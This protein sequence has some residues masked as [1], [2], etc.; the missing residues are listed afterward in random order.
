MDEGQVVH[1]ERTAGEC[2]ENEENHGAVGIRAVVSFKQEVVLLGLGCHTKVP[3][4]G[5]L[6][7]QKSICSQYW[8]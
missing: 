4:T 5:W 3:Q 6:K 1:P 8:K 2:E 7:P